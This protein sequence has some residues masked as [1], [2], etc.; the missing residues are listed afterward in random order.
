M[1]DWL[2]TPIAWLLKQWHALFST[3]LD[4]ASGA[5]WALAIA[6]L[7]VTV[8]LL[9]FPVSTRQVRSQRAVQ[10]L[11]PQVQALRAQ[12]RDD[13]Q[14]L[15]AAIRGLQQERG[16]SPLAGCLPA[17]LQVPV[18]LALLHVL[19]RLAPGKEG[20]Y[21]WSYELTQQAAEAT[22]AGAPVSSS[23]TDHPAGTTTAVVAVVLIVAMC[24]TS[25]LTQRATQRRS[26]PVTGQAATVQ[27][28]LLYG[29]PTSLA[30]TGFF[31]PVGV[32]L[33]WTTNN[34]WT[35][36]QQLYVLRRFPPPGSPAA[37]AA[38]GPPPPS[39]SRT[40]PPRPGAR[41]DRGRGS[42]RGRGPG[43]RR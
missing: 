9:L 24:L 28:L 32:L 25:F 37:L 43:R 34:L 21:S 10:E 18:F 7:V 13:P 3:V 12:H 5:A 19:R 16:V 31:F 4:P 20:L 8:R 36:G 38:A 1:L 33:Y 14:A 39:P 6:L 42:G 23:F 17:L 22:L 26:G 11:Q 27:R 29:M 15:A 35:L 2:Y 40:L 30:V 41:P